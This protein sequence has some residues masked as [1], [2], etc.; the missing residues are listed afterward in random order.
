MDVLA[1]PAHAHALLALNFLGG[2]GPLLL[3]LVLPPLVWLAVRVLFPRAQM[4]EHVESDGHRRTDPVGFLRADGSIIDTTLREGPKRVG[5]VYVKDGRGVVRVYRREEREKYDEVGWVDAAGKVYEWT[6]EGELFDNGREAGAVSPDGRRHWYELWLRRH[7][8]VPD[9]DP[10]PAGRCVEAIR[11]RG[12][13]PGAPT[14]LARAG[15]ALLLYRPLAPAPET[16]VR[17]PPPEFW[18]TA[19]PATLVFTAAFFLPGLVQLFDGNYVLFPLLG[20]EWSFVLTMALLYVAVWAALH[21]AK[22]VMLSNSYQARSLLTMVNRQT[23]I[24]AWSV[25]GIA[26]AAVGIVWTFTV[27]AY[28]YFPLFLANFAGFT[29]ARFRAPSETWGVEPRT[30]PRQRES[31]RE[32]ARRRE[33]AEDAAPGVEWRDYRWQLDSPLRQLWFDARVSFLPAEVEELRR[34]DPSR[35]GAPGGADRAA[36]AAE[37]VRSGEQARQVRRVAAAI[38]RRSGEER[39]TKVE[40]IQA[41]L[42]FVQE[43]NI[44]DDAAEGGDDP[45]H[46]AGHLRSPAETLYEQRGRDDC[47]AV[48]A[49]ALMRVLGY[50]VLLLLSPGTRRAAIAVGGIPDLGEA[51]G[52]LTVE[53]EARRYYFCEMTG[54]GWRVGQPAEGDDR[55][56]LRAD[57]DQVIVDLSKDLPAGP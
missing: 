51:G 24:S 10:E 4:H 22:I 45:A 23:G 25:V 48:L 32:E 5:Q 30:R 11:L 39:L 46:A 47:K 9:G 35:E 27:D 20:Q 13:P 31:E 2:F 54:E 56:E 55:L 42:D 38:A 36:A 37:L 12:G 21:W 44:A 57:V 50:P 17:L 28:Q 19:L 1:A 49:A 53:H 14:L 33:E 41:A 29:A 26:L 15:A 43:P 34:P 7:A 3:A 40:E 8:D 6:G 16:A 52:A 18:D